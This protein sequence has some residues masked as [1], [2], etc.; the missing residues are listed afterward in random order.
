MKTITAPARSTRPASN[1]LRYAGLGLLLLAGLC[2]VGAQAL[3][4]T[5]V[6]TPAGEGDSYFCG[7]PADSQ[8]EAT[9]RIES[10]GDLGDQPG[11]ILLE[12]DAKLLSKRTLAVEANVMG[13]LLVALGFIVWSRRREEARPIPRVAAGVLGLFWGTT[14]IVAVNLFS[15]SRWTWLALPAGVIV[16][17]LMA[18]TLI[19]PSF[20]WG[21]KM[22]GLA[23]LIPAAAGL[24]ELAGLVEVG[25]PL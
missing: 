9:A 11:V 18:W 15:F 23:L 2:L 10:A 25:T 21:R 5:P 13:G 7:T 17:T 4:R 19:R 14:W 22:I 6:F 1:P 3:Y 16:M 20:H 8:S 12:C 24:I